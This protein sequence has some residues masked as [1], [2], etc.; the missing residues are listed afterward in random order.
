MISCVTYCAFLTE[1]WG[2]ESGPA[3]W[4]FL[5]AKS[6]VVWD[7]LVTAQSCSVNQMTLKLPTHDKVV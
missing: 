5:L 6:L 1:K 4:G 7:P 2:L 3:L